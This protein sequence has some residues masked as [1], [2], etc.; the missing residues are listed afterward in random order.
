MNSFLLLISIFRFYEVHQPIKHLEETI[1]DESQSKC[2]HGGQGRVGQPS[3]SDENCLF[4]IKDA[5][6][7]HVDAYD[8][9]A[10]VNDDDDGN[11]DGDDDDERSLAG[12]ICSFCA[13]NQ[14]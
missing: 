10:N 1:G 12:F 13:P 5:E 9:D 2:S 11:D 3:V 8:H 6:L 7:N 14:M 4:I